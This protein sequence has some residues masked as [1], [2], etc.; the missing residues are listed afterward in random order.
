VYLSP[1]DLS[2][3][4]ELE[5]GPGLKTDLEALEEV[6]SFPSSGRDGRD[7]F[8]GIHVKAAALFLELLR[9]SPFERGNRQVALLAVVVFL[10]L[11]GFDVVADDIDLA[12]LTTMASGGDL[13]MIEIAAAFEAAT[14]LLDLPEDDGY[15]DPPPA[16]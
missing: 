16:R 5:V 9:R 3:L 14:V 15:V 7:L 10:N 12:D 6:A 4:A 8:P 11:N 13:S 1:R 2:S